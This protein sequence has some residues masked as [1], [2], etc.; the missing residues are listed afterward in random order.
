MFAIYPISKVRNIPE[1]K[2]FKPPLLHTK[3]FFFRKLM[4]KFNN[5]FIKVVSECTQNEFQNFH[6]S[7]IDQY[8]IVLL[9][10]CKAVMNDIRKQYERK[11][12][13]KP[14]SLEVLK[15]CI[16]SY[17]MNVFNKRNDCGSFPIKPHYNHK[18]II[19]FLQII[20]FNIN[21]ILIINAQFKIFINTWCRKLFSVCKHDVDAKS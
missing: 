20:Q 15:L 5:S 6:S 14:P 12:R 16:M 11:N 7:L 8:G 2:S 4:F 3:I 10:Y 18:L 1:K 21:A 17:S 19:N 9:L 13:I